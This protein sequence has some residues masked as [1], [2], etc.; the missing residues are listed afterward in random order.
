MTY[1][2]DPR[3]IRTQ[4]MLKEALLT[5]L[6]EGH[7]FHQISI[8]KLTKKA[9]LNRTTFYLH[10]QNINE[11]KEHLTNDILQVLTD[12]IEN[13]TSIFDTNRKDNL[14][15]LLD[16]LLDQR[17]H[18][19]A[20]VQ[21]EQVEKHLH[22]LMKDLIVTRR[23][24]SKNIGRKIIVDTDVKTASIIGVIMWWLKNGLHLDSAYIADQINLMYRS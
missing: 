2:E 4:E 16:Y 21:F 12:K 17:N 3:T 24:H 23:S 20:L 19:L 10:Y 5:L 15:Q 6:Q 18:I 1:K 13:L 14:I 7:S 11:L 8:Q 9:N 22:L